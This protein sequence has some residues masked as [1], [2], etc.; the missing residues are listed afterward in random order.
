MAKTSSVAKNEQRKK[1]ALFTN[2]REKAVIS[3]YDADD[4]YKIPMLLHREGLDMP[5][6]ILWYIAVLAHITFLIIFT[7]RHLRFLH[8]QAPNEPAREAQ[9]RK[10]TRGAAPPHSHHSTSPAP[11][12]TPGRK[13]WRR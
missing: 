9:H 3:A 7:M 2:V 10:S 13:R 11:A 6:K 12:S 8:K 4:L 5:S 1:I